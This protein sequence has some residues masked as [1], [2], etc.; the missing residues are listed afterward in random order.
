M[1]RF[2]CM[3]LLLAATALAQDAS[4]GAIRGSVFDSSGGRIHGAAIALMNVATGS[5]MGGRRTPTDV[6]L[7]ICF[8]RGNTRP[9]LKP[10]AC[11]R[12]SRPICALRS[13][14]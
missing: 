3:I 12:K 10:P 4:T 11:R 8:R 9:G 6:L 13:A 2:V 14:G 1:P 5:A 7:L